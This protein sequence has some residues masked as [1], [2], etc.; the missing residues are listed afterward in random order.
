METR[1]DHLVIGGGIIGLSAAW[2]L[3]RRGQQVLL[4]E[5]F[6]PGHSRGA[7]HGATRNMNNA[8]TEDYYLDLYDEALQL[9]RELERESGEQLL[10]LCGLV[11][12]GDPGVISEAHAALTARGAAAE[13][14][15]AEEAAS[16]WP[17]M[18]FEGTVLLN[19]DAGR[20]HSAT[21]LEVFAALAR[22]HGADIR[23]GQRVTDL[24]VTEHG[25]EVTAV[26]DS[27][28]PTVFN[29]ASVIVAAGAWSEQ[30]LRGLVELP[31]LQVTEEHPAHFQIRPQMIEPGGEAWWPSFNRFVPGKEDPQDGAV[32]G[33]LTPG[34]GVKVG[35][36]KVGDEVN[37]DA[38]RFRG[39]DLSREALR[40]YVAEWFPG[41]DPDTAAEISCTYTSTADGRFVLD[42]I[43]AVTVAAGFSGHG[44]KF[45]PATGRILADAAM[46][47]SFPPDP[48]RLAAH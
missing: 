40:S 36:H 27:G 47:I 34:E 39:S 42:R 24:R 23:F 2:N 41:L 22:A 33:M 10:T 43:G 1:V 45:A 30:L 18:K 38:R 31:P 19:R 16:R 17:G 15:C 48:F 7:S 37:P 26:D 44:F 3:A 8:Y 4:L 28:S 13:L 14:L 5:R 20:I 6:E 46:G 29:A 12:Q 9:W 35:F 32:Y 11:S 25:T 21:A